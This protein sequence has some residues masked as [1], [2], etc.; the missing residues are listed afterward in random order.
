MKKN[1]I[2]FSKKQSVL[3]RWAVFIGQNYK[4]KSIGNINFLYDEVDGG[5]VG[6]LLYDADRGAGELLELLEYIKSKNAKIDVLAFNSK[7]NY[8]DG[9]ELFKAGVKAYANSY[10][11]KQ[12]LLQ[13]IFAIEGGNIWVYPEFMVSLIGK[14]KTQSQ[15][16]DDIKQILTGREFELAKMVA[17]GL[18][19]KEIAQNMSIS[20]NTVK[21]HLSSIYEKLNI[22]SRL[23]LAV[24]I[25]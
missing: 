14:I 1:I 9:V 3:E 24:L 13:A 17:I 6:L 4:A 22:H 7:P 10:I 18:G 20:E 21:A 19:N 5:Y 15:K 23:S 12:N 2:L 11:S 25:K 8:N 16:S